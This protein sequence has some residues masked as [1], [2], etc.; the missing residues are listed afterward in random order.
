MMVKTIRAA[1][2]IIIFITLSWISVPV[3]C[4]NVGTKAGFFMRQRH[5]L[6]AAST[7]ELNTDSEERKRSTLKV[8]SAA[9]KWP[10]MW[11]YP[12]DYL[13]KMDGYQPNEISIRSPDDSNFIRHTKDY[14]QDTHNILIVGM[15]DGLN[16]ITNIGAFWNSTYYTIG[17]DV[18]TDFQLPYKSSSF[19][20]V[21]FKSGIEVL[22]DP[23]VLFK[24]FWR[25]MKP[26]GICFSWFS[27]EPNLPDK[28]AVPIK[29][30][31]TMTLEQKIWIAGSYFH[32]SAVE[33]WDNI[34]AY[35]VIG[36]SG[37]K[38]VVFDAL[39]A[40]GGDFIV[41]ARKIESLAINDDDLTASFKKLLLSVKYLQPEDVKFLSYRLAAAY[42]ESSNAADREDIVNRIDRL[43]DIYSV[44]KGTRHVRWKH[45]HAATSI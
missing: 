16:T 21:I 11:P 10:P 38:T 43:S 39:G 12:K 7:S 13:D 25:V 6:T 28:S 1:S 27:S 26:S 14:V 23:T 30:W 15:G 42:N 2:C 44:L 33:G 9:W 18:S 34:E 19:D 22:S 31:A 20:S 36:N 32:Y 35:D 17:G 37:D 41:Q 29:M 40:S 8:P 45:L 24:E 3:L 4:F 5:H